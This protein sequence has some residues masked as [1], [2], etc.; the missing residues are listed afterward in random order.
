MYFLA[1]N[2]NKIF[3]FKVKSKDVKIQY[4]QLAN[5]V[6]DNIQAAWNDA[7]I[8]QLTIH[9][10]SLARSSHTVSKEQ[11]V[12]AMQQIINQRQG[13]SVKYCFLRDFVIKNSSECILGC[14]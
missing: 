9:C 1:L 11:A 6:E 8:L 5:A 4:L 12:L 3:R 10:M 14:L 13:D 2:Q 7:S